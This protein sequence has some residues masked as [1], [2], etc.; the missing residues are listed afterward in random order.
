MGRLPAMLE[1]AEIFRPR[2]GLC[3]GPSGPLH[4]Q[5]AQ[6]IKYSRFQVTQRD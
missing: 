1:Q 3:P 4:A 6:A 2:L 5:L